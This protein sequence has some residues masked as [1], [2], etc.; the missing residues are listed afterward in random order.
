MERD[1]SAVK[2]GKEV[3]RVN[4]FSRLGDIGIN[5]DDEVGVK[6]EVSTA[7]TLK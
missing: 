1:R 5:D 6:N 2:S 7:E 4:T 3:G